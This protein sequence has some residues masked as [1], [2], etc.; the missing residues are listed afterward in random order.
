MLKEEMDAE[1]IEP[2]PTL[3]SPASICRL[4]GKEKGAWSNFY[5]QL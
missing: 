5:E 3:L 1:N 4:L 2:T